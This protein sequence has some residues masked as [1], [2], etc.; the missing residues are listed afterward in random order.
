MSEPSINLPLDLIHSICRSSRPS[1]YSKLICVSRLFF[2]SVAPLVWQDLRGVE[3]L[4]R[5]IPGVECTVGVGEPN[6]SK[7]IIPHVARLDFRRF[8]LYG[9]FVK[10]LEIYDK[11]VKKHSLSNWRQF[12]VYAREHV[13]L[14]N[15]TRLT[16]ETS[17]SRN[18]LTWIRVF[19][20]PT[21]VE[22]SVVPLAKPVPVIPYL[23]ASALIRYIGDICSNIEHLA[24]F[25]DREDST[26][27]DQDLVDD[28]QMV[29]FWD[30]SLPQYLSKISS[31]RE[32]HATTE[33]LMPSAVTHLARLLHLESLVIYPSKHSFSFESHVPNGSFQALRSFSLYRARHKLVALV[34]RL[35]FL[36]NITSL[37]LTFATLPES[38]HERRS[39]VN[40]LMSLIGDHCPSLNELTI[41]FDYDR[42][43]DYYIDLIPAVVLPLMEKLPLQKIEVLSALFSPRDSPEFYT[44]IPSVW[45]QVIVLKLPDEEISVDE[46]HWFSELPRLEHLTL[47]L[48]LSTPLPDSS[49]VLRRTNLCFE[50][51]ESSHAVSIGGDVYKIALWLLSLWPTLKRVNWSH[52]EVNSNRN[53]NE[54]EH[55]GSTSMTIA[56][57]LNSII[58]L[59]RKLGETKS[60]LANEA[61][62]SQA[63]S[64]FSPGL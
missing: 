5:L 59:L 6:T 51:L 20:S 9:P 33:I 52:G 57:G 27:Y 11:D 45:S 53:M 62:G 39:W 44:L 50:T 26:E 34:W 61:Y 10:H 21:L 4:F 2:E 31:L 24:L 22:I 46:L 28:R 32:L 35:Q 17:S 55:D 30:S 3:K 37:K 13:L 23:E 18:Q 14:P 38:P 42:K 48:S 8:H 58:D 19:L 40:S 15:L 25:P 41:D 29:D 54:S 56:N 36:A 12:M 64:L 43:H 1:D 16:L 60:R 47:G 49:P 7:I 63:L